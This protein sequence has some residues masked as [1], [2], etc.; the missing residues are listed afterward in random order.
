[1][2]DDE[3]E[4]ED[5]NGDEDEEEDQEVPPAPPSPVISDITY[6]SDTSEALEHALRT[7]ITLTFEVGESSMTPRVTPSELRAELGRLR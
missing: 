3:D 1:M 4:M 7:E 6:K 2:E 5:D